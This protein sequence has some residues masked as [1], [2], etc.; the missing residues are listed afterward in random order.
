MRS[1]RG[2]ALI[3]AVLLAVATA[4]AAIGLVVVVGA[5]RVG[6]IHTVGGETAEAIARTGLERAE[7]Y[8]LAVSTGEQDFDRVLD[9]LLEADCR[10]VQRTTDTGVVVERGSMYLPRFTESGVA[11]TTWNGLRWRM[12]PWG[13]GAYLVRYEDDQDDGIVAVSS[14]DWSLATSNTRSGAANDA[15]NLTAPPPG[16][17]GVHNPARDRDRAIYANIVGIYPGTNPAQ[18]LHRSVLRKLI[19]DNRKSGPGA[20]RVGGDVT[21]VSGGSMQLCSDESGVTTSGN[22]QTGSPGSC[23]CGD[24]TGAT[25][26]LTGGESG[27]CGACCTNENPYQPSTTATA[28]PPNIP[29]TSAARWY[30][31]GSVCNFYL[32]GTGLYWWDAPA[33]RGASDTCG[34]YAGNLVPP[35]TNTNDQ[36]A[37]WTPIFLVAPQT[38][39]VYALDAARGGSTAEVSTCGTD[40]MQWKPRTDVVTYDLGA[41]PGSGYFTGGTRATTG[42]KPNWARCPETATTDLRWNPPSADPGNGTVAVGCTTCNGA[43][44]VITWRNTA[45]KWR[46]EGAAASLTAFPSGAYV[47]QGSLVWAASGGALPTSTTDPTKWPMITLIVNGNVNVPNGGRMYLGVGTRKNQYPSLIVD[48]DLNVEDGA[49]MEALGSIFVTDD[50]LVESGG[51]NGAF[52]YGMVTV[53][54][55]VTTSSG[56]QLNWDYDVPLDGEAPPPPSPRLSLPLSF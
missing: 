50:L 17:G 34:A 49:R 13:G 30:D 31:W 55:D 5:T 12:V 44:P 39:P 43:N 1:P 16:S 2:F 25:V 4:A 53:G 33:G 20:L 29:N 35:S 6:V 14:P 23:A 52:F 8:A 7:A 21:T 54:D 3:T 32:D 56:G 42:T 37:C 26:V 18:A 40:C 22:I 48:G 36:G 46:F 51:G 15:T 41:A 47:H 10:T 9:P 38:V 27:S 19:V 24:T 28:P 45:P 11:I